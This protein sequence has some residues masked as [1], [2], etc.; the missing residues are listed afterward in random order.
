MSETW[1]FLRS[2]PN[3]AAYNMALDEALLL[4]A[5]KRRRPLLRV[6]SWEK[7]SVS[8]GYFQKFPA[9]RAGQYEI[10]RRPT[11]GGLVYH[12]DNLDTTYTVITPLGHSLSTMGASAAYGAI[13]KAVA[14]AIGNQSQVTHHESSLRRDNYECF[15]NPV[16]GDVVV[17]GCKLAGGAQRRSKHGMLHQG[18]IAAQV[19]AE[20]LVRGFTTVH[21]VR[22][23]PYAL[24]DEERAFAER[25]V[26]EKYATDPWNRRIS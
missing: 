26:R 16:A 13:H 17:D 23:E 24:T 4:T 18:S 9:N 1:D 7:P 21:G 10:V 25:F 20:Q 19:T 8:F 15:Q 3:S 14:V 6:Y 2:P 11:G 12:G 5:A 22:F